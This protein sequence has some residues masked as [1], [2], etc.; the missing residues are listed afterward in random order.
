MSSAFTYLLHSP[1]EF[2]SHKTQKTK[3]GAVM[4]KKLATVLL[5]LTFALS[6]IYAWDERKEERIMVK[7]IRP[8]GMGG[9]FTAVADDEN[10]VFYNPAGLSQRRGWLLQVFSIDARVNKETIN[11][12]SEAA[13]LGGDGGSGDTIK[14]ARDTLSGKDIDLSLSLPNIFFISSPFSINNGNSLSF[15]IGEYTSVDIGLSVEITAP[16]WAF[17][18]GEISEKREIKEEDIYT[19]VPMDLVKKFLNDRDTSN[20]PI[21]MTWLKNKIDR[22]RAGGTDAENA[23]DE[24]YANLTAEAK[25][26]VDDLTDSG[27]VDYAKIVEKLNEILDLDELLKAGVVVDIY[28]TGI[29]DI[30]FAYRFKSLDA[31][32]LPGELSVGANVKYIQRVKARKLIYLDASDAAK[33]DDSFDSM[34]LAVLSG[35]GFG[36]DLGTI[37]HFTP[38]WNFGLQIS[39]IYTRINYDKA[40]VKYPENA[41]DS[42]FTHTATID[43]QI[44]IGASYVPEVIYYWKDRYFETKNR[45]T[46]ALD[47]RDLGGAYEKEFMDKFHLGVEYRFSPFALRAGINK[48]YP[49]FGLGIE[50]GFFQIS[51]AFYGDESYLAKAFGNDKT[52]YYHDVL[53][54]WKFGHHKGRPFGKGLKETVKADKEKPAQDKSLG[55]KGAAEKSSE[56]KAQPKDG[57]GR[58][59]ELLG[60]K[61]QPKEE[62]IPVIIP[63]NDGNKPNQPSLILQ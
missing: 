27:D 61:G 9:A 25:E 24:I 39:D 48:K 44:N 57:D 53:I 60:E 18:L 8:M 35:Q 26:I 1:S 36:L 30:P 41:P 45:F 12:I 29:I 2:Y 58:H 62:P 5:V 42:D 17:T 54:A 32:K 19:T 7:G 31:V 52:V 20:N 11:L 51:Y 23:K 15:G 43:P 6:N 55:E 46:F 22:I 28:A 16:N 40:I 14:Q 33:L 47:L 37:Y 34:N 10:A 59:Y 56:E 4:I 21:N 50:L 13:D 38:Q 63:K 3:K 49:A